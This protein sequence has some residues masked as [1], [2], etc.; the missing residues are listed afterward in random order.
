M[1]LPLAE[2]GAASFE[3][4]G[5]DW[6]LLRVS[7]FDNAMR[8]ANL[9]YVIF[10]RSLAPDEMGNMKLIDALPANLIWI[11][12]LDQSAPST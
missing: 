12:E 4:Q 3:L 6:Y 11:Y 7:P 9:K 1:G 5:T 2:G 10:P 8:E